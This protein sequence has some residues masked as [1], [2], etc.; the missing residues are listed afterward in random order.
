MRWILLTTIAALAATLSLQPVRHHA[1]TLHSR[2]AA[3]RL[4]VGLP[5]CD[6]PD[7]LSQCERLMPEAGWNLPAAP[8]EDALAAAEALRGRTTP[9]ATQSSLA[10][11]RSRARSLLASQVPDDAKHAQIA[12][13]CAA[14]RAAQR[15]KSAELA[16]ELAQKRVEK[17]RIKDKTAALS[18]PLL[19]EGLRAHASLRQLDKFEALLAMTDDIGAEPT[20]LS[21]ALAGAASAGYLQHAAAANLTLAM[22]N[23]SAEVEAMEV[24]MAA[25]L[26]HGDDAGA[27]DVY[28]AMKARAGAGGPHAT[29]R[30]HALAARAAS[31]RAPPSCP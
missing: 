16:F 29:A 27:I 5:A 2:H 3:C 22:H 17:R 8:L 23:H 15:P 20:V 7:V 1:H 31:A 26:G 30:A 10:S 28:L 24:W 14:A 19:G 9:A 12:A 11:T 13:L 4:Q 18:R 25:R 6:I 21:A